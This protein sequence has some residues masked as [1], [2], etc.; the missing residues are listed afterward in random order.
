VYSV[1]EAT[2][3]FFTLDPPR[4]EDVASDA[5][6]ALIR[7]ELRTGHASLLGFHQSRPRIPAEYLCSILL[8]GLP[9]ERNSL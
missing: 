5:G 6:W 9:L 7:P 8:Q 4:T 2:L 3:G 1:Y